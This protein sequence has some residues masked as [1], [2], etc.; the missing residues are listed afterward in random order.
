MVIFTHPFTQA[1]NYKVLYNNLAKSFEGTPKSLKI[2][3]Q[4]TYQCGD[5]P[6]DAL[7]PHCQLQNAM[8]LEKLGVKLDSLDKLW[9]QTCWHKPCH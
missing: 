9:D 3:L 5:F 4:K 2:G 6:V 1:T 7:F 8:L